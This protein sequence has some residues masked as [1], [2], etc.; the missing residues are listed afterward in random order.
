M[1]ATTHP[2]VKL[3]SHLAIIVAVIGYLARI[4]MIKFL[5]S[6]LVVWRNVLGGANLKLWNYGYER[7]V[8]AGS[9]CRSLPKAS[10]SGGLM[11]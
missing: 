8:T 5:Q 2:T 1:L 10:I 3:Q 6:R 7:S 11:G 9:F 4:A